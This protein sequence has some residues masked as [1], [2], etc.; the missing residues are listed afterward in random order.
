[1][2]ASLVGAKVIGTGLDRLKQPAVLGGVFA[3]IFIALV[4]TIGGLDGA[5]AGFRGETFD[6]FA[7]M[8]I[9]F[10]MF[11][12]AFEMDLG[13]LRRVWKHSASTAWFGVLVP[14]VLGAVVGWLFNFTLIESMVI[15]TVLTATSVGITVRT[16]MDVNAIHTRTSATI[17]SAAVIDDVIGIVLLT[18]VLGSGRTSTFMSWNLPPLIILVIG[19]VLFFLVTWVLG[20]RYIGPV[21]R[22]S[23]KLSM[24]K[25]LTSIAIAIAFVYAALANM[26][27]VAAVTGAFLA[28][29]I[30]NQTIEAK[31]V[32][33]DLRTIGAAF[34]VP[35]FFVSIGVMLIESASWQSIVMVIPLAAAMIL[36][37][38]FGKVAGCGLGAKL[39]G[40]SGRESLR[41]GV[42]MMPRLEVALVVVAAAMHMGAFESLGH[43]S[44][45]LTATVMLI[46]VSTM[47]TPFAIRWS[48]KGSED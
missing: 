10:L 21:M 19:L 23:S 8:G 11:I 42:G 32:V 36:V 2:A 33:R 1:V 12:S 14:F 48:I 4:L 43:Q 7:E 34:F 35:L 41:V 24:P 40:M 6:T 20:K 44:Q 22:L 38:L 16:L 45:I 18:V 46:L 39:M 15:G 37:G 3:G 47:I 31:R 9:I 30:I 17:L 29:L 26:V 25:S 5:L 28:G 27:G 13:E